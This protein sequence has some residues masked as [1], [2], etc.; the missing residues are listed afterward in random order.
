M[1]MSYLTP[2]IRLRRTPFSNRVDR[3]GAKAYTVYNHMLLA[4]YYETPE[5]DYRHLK[6]AVQVWDVSCERQVE[7]KGPDALRLV[8]MTTPRDMSRIQDDQ[9]YYV[10]MVDAAGRMMNDPVTVCLNQDR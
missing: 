7:V 10:P 1:S 4:S 2:S 9:C 6:S 8:Q 3:A 5:E